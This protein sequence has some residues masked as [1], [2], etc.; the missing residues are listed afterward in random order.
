MSESHRRLEVER[1]EFDLSELEHSEDT[2]EL[3]RRCDIIIGIDSSRPES[4]EAILFG[5]DRTCGSRRKLCSS[6]QTNRGAIC[7]RQRASI[8][9]Q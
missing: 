3:I 4:N 7:C 2:R 6:G 5:R 1:R 8:G 9:P